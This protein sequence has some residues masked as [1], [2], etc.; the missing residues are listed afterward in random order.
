[1][2][3]SIPTS[4]PPCVPGR[5][6]PTAAP[7]LSTYVPCQPVCLELKSLKYYLVSYRDVG[8]VQEHAASR[9][10]K[11]LVSLYAVPGCM[12]VL[13]D[14]KVRGGLH[15]TVSVEHGTRQE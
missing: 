9:I 5:A 2:S 8:I 12:K 4:S 10:L 14:Y 3:V 11:D 15:T 6:C 13:L 7:L 1:M